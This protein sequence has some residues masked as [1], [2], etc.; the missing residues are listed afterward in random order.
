MIQTENQ[1]I[2][3]SRKW[4][5]EFIIGLNICPFAHRP[6]NDNKIRF[7]SSS[8]SE[9]HKILEDF[10]AEVHD[11]DSTNETS[12]TLITIPSGVED[13][14]DFLILIEMANEMLDLQNLNEDFQ[15]A[16]FH[17]NYCFDGVEDDDP[18]NLTNRSPYPMLHIIRTVEVAAA[19]ES[20]G[21]TSEISKQNIELLRGMKN[22]N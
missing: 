8:A 1:Y 15:L 18:G 10:V 7:C 13:F 12:T 14:N 2:E 21:D 9:M 5:L 22:C 20:Y 17:P 19:I 4:V 3:A 11:L 16:H 6:Y